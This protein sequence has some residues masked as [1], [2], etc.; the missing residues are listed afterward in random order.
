[1]L[2]VSNET[3]LWRIWVVAMA[4]LVLNLPVLT[5]D[6]ELGDL[7]LADLLS[8]ING[9]DPRRI[10]ISHLERIYEDK[11]TKCPYCTPSTKSSAQERR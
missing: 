5:M 9:I 2:F 4:A 10:S 6:E 3:I 8:G 11:G 1:V 7:A